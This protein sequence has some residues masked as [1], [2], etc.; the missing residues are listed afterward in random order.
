MESPLSF[1]IFASISAR[2][3]LKPHTCPA[4][5]ALA[6]LLAVLVVLGC[7]SRTTASRSDGSKPALQILPTTPLKVRGL[8]FQAGERVLVSVGRRKA[9][10]TANGDGFFVVTIPGASRCDVVRV[11]ARGSAGS[12]AVVKVLPSPECAPARSG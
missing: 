10:A 6:V 5:R 12:Y 1:A 8:H 2:S 4:M 9:Q 7:S 11:L 3:I